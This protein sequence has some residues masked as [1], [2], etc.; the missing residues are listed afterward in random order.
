VGW[1]QRDRR[2]LELQ[3]DLHPGRLWGWETSFDADTALVLELH[4]PPPRL[5]LR[6][7]TIALDPGHGG[8]NWSA[9]GPTGTVEKR[10]NLELMEVVR[11][12]LA[13]EGA[14][15][16]VTREEDRFLE[17]HERIELARDAGADLLI[18]L[19]HNGLPQGINPHDHHG[20]TVLYYQPH[21]LPLA[22]QLQAALTEGPP[23]WEGDG[24]RYQNLALTRAS[25]APAVLL[26]AGYLL[27][28][29]E[30]QRLSLPEHQE[31]L[32][33]RIV[34]GLERYLERVRPEAQPH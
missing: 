9:I 21:S 30:E 27:H 6:N 19:H 5:R 3:L 23:R 10:I 31:A 17:L 11:T 26:E 34:A 1:E 8:W 33:A 2:T 15:V 32:A 7:L 13:E 20:P 22:R 29:G 24:V 14:E 16:V 28:P 25:F 18:S 12:A 4:A